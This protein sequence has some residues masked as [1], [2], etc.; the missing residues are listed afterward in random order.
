MYDWVSAEE[1]FDVIAPAPEA[2]W[3]GQTENDVPPVVGL[4]AH[5]KL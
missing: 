4:M 5:V 2:R 3:F 1:T